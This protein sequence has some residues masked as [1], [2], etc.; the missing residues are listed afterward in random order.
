MSLCPRGRENGAH[1]G[2]PGSSQP[3]GEQTEP[4]MPFPPFLSLL[5]PLWDRPATT[6]SPVL[7]SHCP[8]GTH[9]CDTGT[10]LCAMGS[11]LCPMGV[12]C[13]MGT[14]LCATGTPLC[15]TRTPLCPNGDTLQSLG[16]T[17]LSNWDIP[18][19]PRHTPLSR[20]VNGNTSLSQMRHP[21]VP[22]GTSHCPKGN[23]LLAQAVTLLPGQ[24]WCHIGV[25]TGPRQGWC[26]TDMRTGLVSHQYQGRVGVTPVSGLS[27]S[28]C[29]CP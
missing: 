16:V 24:G 3:R 11:L 9:P 22:T 27:P 7:H 4:A 6:V 15:A 25:R 23:I 29:P 21:T 19:S 17:H 1:A 28:P 10:L 8:M 20:G 12:L 5:V 18:L 2:I 14:P 26:H 13:A